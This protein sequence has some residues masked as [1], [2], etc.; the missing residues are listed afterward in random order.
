MRKLS[1]TLLTLALL[2]FLIVFGMPFLMGV[3]IQHE[4]PALIKRLS[5]HHHA[6]ATVKQ[7]TRGWFSSHAVIHVV[8]KPKW[9][10]GKTHAL[11]LIQFD[12]NET[13]LHGPVIFTQ[14]NNATQWTLARALITNRINAKNIQLHSTTTWTLSNHLKT[15]FDASQLTLLSDTHTL[16]LTGFTG[17]TDYTKNTKKTTSTIKGKLLSL[18]RVNPA[19]QHTQILTL[20]NIAINNTSHMRK[21]LWVGQR[22]IQI[23][24]VTV[25][26]E[27]NKLLT[28]HSL[29]LRAQQSQHKKNTQLTLQINTGKIRYGDKTIGP[30][31]LAL[32]VA[33]LNTDALSQ[34]TQNANTLQ[35]QPQ[36]QHPFQQL[37][38]PFVT[39]VSKGISLNVNNVRIDTPLGFFKATGHLKIPPVDFANLAYIT[40]LSDM[41]L[42]ISMSRALL[43]SWL[44][45]H[46]KQQE[47]QARK[48]HFNPKALHI[49]TPKARAKLL[50]HTLI[51]HKQLIASGDQLEMTLTYVRGKLRINGTKPRLHLDYLKHRVPLRRTTGW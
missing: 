16:K 23:D 42:H 12:I 26:N 8:I 31:T 48:T 43:A 2:L 44:I 22:S 35:T 4:Y 37:Q 21:G 25:K 11:D 51:K 27:T 39:L 34:L 36:T 15:H 1:T 9:L 45:E 6:E 30:T 29:L 5:A 20:Q 19:T 49:T 32:T 7:Y 13:I 33:N 47:K 17:T 46:F 41:R 50:I 28:I 38:R 3:W 14:K 10:K 40:L 18:I 24:N